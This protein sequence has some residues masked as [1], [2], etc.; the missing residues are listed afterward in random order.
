MISSVKQHPTRGALIVAPMLLAMA[1]HLAAPSMARACGCVAPQDPATPVVQAGERIVFYVDQG[2]VTAHIQIQYSGPAEE[3]GWLLP[4]PAIPE[5]ELGSED[6]F[7]QILPATQPVYRTDQEFIGDCFGGRDN[8][9]EPQPESPSPPSDPSDDGG[10]DGSPLV[11][12]DSVGPFDIAI[13]RA[14]SKEPMLQ[15]LNDNGFFVPNGTEEVVDPYINEGAYFLALGLLSGEEAGDIQPLVVE[16]E[17]DL[18]MIPIILTS[19]AADPD[20]GVQ[21]W[22]LGEDRAIPRNYRHTSINDAALDWLN[23]GQNYAQ[24]VTDAVDEA[25]G[26]HSFV[27][28]YAGSSNV[29]ID[30]L[31]PQGRFG[32]LE[33]LASLTEPVQFV[34]YLRQNQYWYIDNQFGAQFYSPQLI[35]ILRS[36]LPI[37]EGLAEFGVTENDYYLSFDFYINTFRLEN[38]ELFEGLDLEYDAGRLAATINERYVQP[39]IAAGQMFRDFPYMTRMFT[40]LSP[41]EMTEDPVFSFNPDLPEVSNRHSGLLSYFCDGSGAPLSTVP[42]R[43][44]TEQGYEVWYPEGTGGAQ[45]GSPVA[46]IS[47]MPQSTY[48]DILREAGAEDREVDNVELISQLLDEEND[49]R[50]ENGAC[51]PDVDGDGDGDGRPGVANDGGC[52]CAAPGDEGIPAGGFALVGLAALL[53]RRRRR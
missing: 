15:W 49:R 50:C 4:M 1:A 36:E 48:I 41:E 44:T 25:E 19:V 53:L 24:V 46:N 8:D 26:H 16:Y 29:M 43:L 32:N 51:D 45:P 27:T 18:P 6:L 21:V 52:G 14:D 9:G 30:V 20:M 22:V 31:D 47:E 35:G 2:K 23:F 42:T 13:L 7:T 38:P 33:T 34:T 17:S 39:T 3:F 11:L 12:R 40:T 10:G 28:E 5:F 37:P